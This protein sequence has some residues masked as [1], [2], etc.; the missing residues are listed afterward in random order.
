MPDGK[1]DTLKFG[2]RRR[3]REAGGGEREKERAVV[4]RKMREG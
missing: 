1:R 2:Q 3:K 4:Q